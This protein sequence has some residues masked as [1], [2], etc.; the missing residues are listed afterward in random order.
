MRYRPVIGLEIHLELNTAS[1]MFCGCSTAFGSNPNTHCCPVCLGLPGSL[2]V[3]NRRAL[4]LGIKAARALKAQVERVSRFDRKN[5]FYPDLPKAYQIS[6]Y[7]LPLAREGT[8]VIP[9]AEGE[10]SV[11][12]ERAHLEEEAGKLIHAG[13]SI[14]EAEHSLVD[15]NR[16]GIPLMEIVTAPDLRSGEE[17]H[18]FLNELRLLLLYNQISDCRMEEG[19]LR[20]DAN[21]SLSSEDEAKL[22]TKVEIKNMNSFRAV[23]MALDYEIQRQKELLASDQAIIQE[24]RHWDEDKKETFSMRGKE[25]ASDYRYFP[26]P[27]LPP[28]ELDQAWIKEVE[29][30][31]TEPPQ[32]RRRRLQVQYGLGK[33]EVEILI[34]T[35]ELGFFFEKAAADFSDFRELANWVTG[36]VMRIIHQNDLDL[37]ELNPSFLVETLSMLEESIINRSVAKEI[38]EEA[39]LRE[40]KPRKLVESRNL[41]KITGAEALTP[42]A[43]EVLQENPKAKS[44]YLEGKKKAL[45]FLIGQV[46]AKTR[47]RADPEE[48]KNILQDKI[49]GVS[50]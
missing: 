29:Q 4:E 48:V 10:R 23:K 7:D 30:E 13:G 28:V 1:K 6:Q 18:I 19:S 2:P 38:L 42:W 37:P 34:S 5:Y 21:I 36:E 25:E 32:E 3:L 47:G 14:M 20:C 24:T 9:A 8:V 16:S 31:L 17:A 49:N 45:D 40:E 44:S 50:E 39:L 27:D 26:E 22:G 15:Y 33:N 35:P 43:E 41:G 46:M 12:I 11:R